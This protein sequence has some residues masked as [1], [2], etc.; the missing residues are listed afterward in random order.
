MTI[1]AL[2]QL[3]AESDKLDRDYRSQ[4]A[5][6]DKRIVA[7]RKE[8]QLEAIS[9]IKAIMDEYGIDPDVLVQSKKQSPKRQKSVVP[10][11]YKGP[12]GETWTGRG[13]QPK[14]LGVNRE[15]FRV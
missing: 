9:K 4:R 6:F 14:W 1:D 15:D 2:A 7:L 13:R 5:S 8:A 10:I 12:N 3:Q 11:K